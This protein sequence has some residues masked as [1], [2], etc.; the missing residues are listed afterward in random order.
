MPSLSRGTGPNIDDPS[1]AQIEAVL[2]ELATG[3]EYF[4]TLN[5]DRGFIQSAEAPASGLIVEYKLADDPILHRTTR[6]LSPEDVATLFGRF[7]AGDLTWTD[8]YAW[9]EQTIGRPEGSD[10]GCLGVLAAVVI[11]ALLG[12]FV[13]LPAAAQDGN[14][15][16]EAYLQ[17]TGLY[18]QTTALERWLSD[19]LA[20]REPGMTAERRTRTAAF[21]SFVMAVGGVTAENAPRLEAQGLDLVHAVTA[22]ARPFDEQ[23]LMAD[24][25]V[26][27]EVVEAPE[28]T[29]PEDGFSA[30]V[31]LAVRQV[32]KGQAP[33]D[34]VVIRRRDGVPQRGEPLDVGRAYLLLLSGGMY[35]YYAASHR[36]REGL[37]EDPAYVPA[38][39]V[40]RQ[41]PVE[42]GRLVWTGRRDTTAAF[43]QIR[44]LDRMLTE[45]SE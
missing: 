13:A 42:D 39:L 28:E 38:Y 4:A 2:Q 21:F 17:R 8:D 32:L 11:T 44:A 25:V 31:H 40:Y 18:E 7:Q 19:E 20:A 15:P 24:L 29:V 3:E 22:D 10:A 1:P 33:G 30:S 43:A 6:S 9:E 26:F 35:D 41:Y 23:A 36:A 34:T 16:R 14:L 27:G 45:A 5:T 37:V 12:L